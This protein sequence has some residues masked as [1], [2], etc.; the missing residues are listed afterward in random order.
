MTRKKGLKG[1]V[2]IVLVFIAL[3]GFFVI[4]QGLLQR[5]GADQDVLII[6]NSFLLLVTLLSYFLARRGLTSSNP[7]QFVRSIYSGILLK[8][9]ICLIAAFVYIAINKK[10]LNKPAFF[11]LMG[12]YLLYTFLEVSVL[13]KALKQQPNA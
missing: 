7:H 6:G 4:G 9:F 12:L 1:V 10:D 3:N 11:T 13:T 2:P 8:L 5:W